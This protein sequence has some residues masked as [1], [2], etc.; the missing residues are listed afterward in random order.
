[1][2]FYH[3]PNYYCDK[4]VD[5]KEQI[6]SIINFRRW[7]S[8]KKGSG[9]LCSTQIANV[10]Y[11]WEEHENV[12]ENIITA[13][14][15]ELSHFTLFLKPDRSTLTI[16]QWISLQDTFI[17]HRKQYLLFGWLNREKKHNKKHNTL[18]KVLHTILLT[19]IFRTKLFFFLFKS[20][21]EQCIVGTKGLEI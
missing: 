2:H 19:D 17:I 13:I 12:G 14:N 4:L 10:D 8:T 3:K 16:K 7:S 5:K 6:G 11:I 1:M 9:K 15:K 21:H 20:D 18:F